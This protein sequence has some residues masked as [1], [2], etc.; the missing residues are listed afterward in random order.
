MVTRNYFKNISKSKVLRQSILM[1]FSKLIISKEKNSCVSYVMVRKIVLQSE[2]FADSTT[3]D[4]GPLYERLRFFGLWLGGTP[5]STKPLDGLYSLGS[6]RDFTLRS[7]AILTL[8]S[9]DFN[10]GIFRILFNNAQH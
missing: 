8:G 10:A 7:I 5:L 1:Y 4:L 9:K 6:K 3:Q 2:D